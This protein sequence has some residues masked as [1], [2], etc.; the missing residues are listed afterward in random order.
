MPKPVGWLGACVLAEDA[1]PIE[2]RIFGRAEM[3]LE[4]LPLTDC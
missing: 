3:D 1:V 2:E 4:A